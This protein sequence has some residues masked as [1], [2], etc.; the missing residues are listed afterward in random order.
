MS[1]RLET[2]SNSAIPKLIG[3]SLLGFILVIDQLLVPMLHIGSL[4]FKIS[5]FLCGFWMQ[6][7]FV[8]P[9]TTI[10]NSAVKSDFFDFAKLILLIM[11]C[12]LL[13]DL[14]IQFFIPVD[15]FAESFKSNTIY[16]LIIMS[17]G[18]GLSSTKFKLKWLV[19]VLLLSCFLNLVFILFKTNLPGW[20]IDFY[21]PP[22]TV[23]SLAADGLDSVDVILEMTRPRGL[24]H[25]P[26][27]SALMVNIIA[28][29]VCV[30]LQ[31]KLI[32]LKP[33]LLAILVIILPLIVS[34]LLSSRG[35]MIVAFVL[36]FFNYK[37]IFK[38]VSRHKKIGFTTVSI[39][40][41]SLLL[42]YLLQSLGP[43]SSIQENLKRAYSIFEIFSNSSN[44]LLDEYEQKNQG[45]ARPLLMLKTAFSRFIYSPIFGSGFNTS[46]VEPFLHGTQHYHNDWFRLMVTSG[47]VGL[48]SMVWVIRKYC[49]TISSILILP[50]LL[51]GL[52]NTFLLNIP[53]VMFYF[54]MIA[55]LRT[56][57]NGQ[58]RS[59]N[60]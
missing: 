14:L 16:I 36:G 4:P 19:Y 48:F 2:T 3:F 50:F 11:M 42:A 34:I 52:V 44:E 41:V 54:F 13:G 58:E 49:L 25:N 29:F 26:N 12:G 27:G 56:K 31:K 59:V 51:P 38:E 23:E 46:H 5:Y 53:A 47:I 17:F 15:S 45:I 22:M 39:L 55:V 60:D 10:R 43:D 35:E 33:S 40:L 7:Y 20:L 24:F 28:L 6:S 30:G 32:T 1:S 8:T 57:L 9:N 21:Y 18:L 37:Y